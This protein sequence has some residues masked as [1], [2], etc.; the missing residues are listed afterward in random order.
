MHFSGEYF[1]N[2]K[3]CDRKQG[4]ITSPNYPM[5]YPHSTDYVWKINVPEN[6]I[7]QLDFDEF[8][9]EF[10]SQCEHDYLD[11]HYLRKKE[12]SVERY[13]IFLVV[14]Q[15]EGEYNYYEVSPS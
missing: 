12:G 3:R 14:L 9:I 2:I 11:I 13:I 7:L 8:D 6:Y 5:A 4:K 15:K 10:S 1:T